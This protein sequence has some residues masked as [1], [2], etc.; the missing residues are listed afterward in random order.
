MDEWRYRICVRPRFQCRTETCCALVAIEEY[1][2][3]EK[4]NDAETKDDID[5][6]DDIEDGIR[7]GVHSI[8]AKPLEDELRSHRL[9]HISCWSWWH[10][11][12]AVKRK[13]LAHMG[14]K[15]CVLEHQGRC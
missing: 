8:I 6:E 13:S 4:R 9:T 14:K 5:D 3:D 7:V 11:C 2:D 1:M 15:R 12:V 10:L